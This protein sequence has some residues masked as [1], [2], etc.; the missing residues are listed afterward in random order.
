MGY[1]T[2][3]ELFSIASDYTL[4]TRKILG[5]SQV[6]RNNQSCKFSEFLSF[7]INL[8]IFSEKLPIYIIP[9]DKSAELNI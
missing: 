7:S 3:L 4:K 8:L 6:L 2:D 5:I 9:H 1:L